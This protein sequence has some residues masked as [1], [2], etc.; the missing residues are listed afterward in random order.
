MEDS[1][2]PFMDYQQ[3]TVFTDMIKITNNILLEPYKNFEYIFRWYPDSYFI[4][5]TRNIF[6]W[7]KSRIR[8]GVISRYC[9]VLGL[10]DEEAVRQYWMQEWYMHHANVLSFFAKS[11]KQLLVYDID[12]HSPEKLTE[13]LSSD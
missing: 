9:S 4:L 8:H 5:N 1:Q 2:D 10:P 3:A 12:K 7:I 6:D 13:F 11:P